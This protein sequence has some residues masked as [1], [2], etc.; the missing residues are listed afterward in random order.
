MRQQPAQA[1]GQQAE[2]EEQGDVEHQVKAAHMADLVGEHAVQFLPVEVVDQGR[3]DEQVAQPGQDADD[4]RG[5]HLAL[6]Q[7]PAEHLGA[8]PLGPAEAGD[9]LAQ[10]PRRQRPATPQHPHQRREEKHE[11]DHEQ[12]EQGQLAVGG[13]EKTGQRRV[14]HELEQVEDQGEDQPGQHRRQVGLEVRPEETNG[15]VA[16]VEQLHVP[17]PALVPDQGQQQEKHGQAADVGEHRQPVAEGQRLQVIFQV[18]Q[19]HQDHEQAHRQERQPPLGAEV[20]AGAGGRGELPAGHGREQPERCQQQGQG[21]DGRQPRFLRRIT[22][23]EHENGHQEAEQVVVEHPVRVHLKMG[24]GLRVRPGRPA[25]NQ[26][27]S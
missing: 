4:A 16:T 5:Q 21:N 13:A 1:A 25:G 12:A 10:R 15:R 24:S 6:E 8:E 17:P 18:E 22:G 2:A 9:V 20:A 19:A 14:W 23:G 27:L 7:R 26:V 3:G 11:E